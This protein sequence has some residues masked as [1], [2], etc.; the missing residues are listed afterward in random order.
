MEEYVVDYKATDDKISLY[1]TDENDAYQIEYFIDK[2]TIEQMF[3]S[4]DFYQRKGQTIIC[5]D[6]KYEALVR[7]EQRYNQ[8]FKL[9]QFYESVIDSKKEDKYANHSFE[10]SHISDMMFIHIFKQLD[11]ANRDELVLSLILNFAVSPPSAS[12]ITDTSEDENLIQFLNRFFD[13]LYSLHIESEF[14]YSINKFDSLSD[15]FIF[16]FSYNYDVPLIKELYLDN[17]LAFEESIGFNENSF[18]VLS[19]QGG[20]TILI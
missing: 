1:I 9:N 8:G 13:D 2:E 18:S 12:E 3:H 4:V 17:I 6:E 11:E 15:S 20:C 16:N 5:V 19:H 14:P 7:F 10:I